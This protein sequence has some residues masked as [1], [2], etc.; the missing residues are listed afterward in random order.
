MNKVNVLIERLERHVSEAFKAAQI[1]D[2]AAIF[3][4]ATAA[5]DIVAQLKRLA[6][7]GIGEWARMMSALL[8]LDKIAERMAGEAEEARDPYA[9]DG[10][11]QWDGE[12]FDEAV[13][14]VEYVADAAALAV[15]VRF[16]EGGH[17]KLAVRSSDAAGIAAFLLGDGAVALTE[18]FEKTCPSLKSFDVVIDDEAFKKSSI[19]VEPK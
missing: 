12:A 9:R 7:L 10:D 8:L 2:E 14:F 19:R 13:A 5:A 1:G 6:P 3:D 16:E 11:F 17:L 18:H 4:A 15:G